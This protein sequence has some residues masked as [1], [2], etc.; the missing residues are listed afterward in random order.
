MRE[1]LGPTISL[2]LILTVVRPV[3]SFAESDG[4]RVEFESGSRRFK[5]KDYQGALA[6]FEKA[7][8]LSNHRPSVIRGLAQTERALE[9]YDRAI[10]HFKEYLES[11]PAEA[12]SIR[13]TIK[14]LELEK[15][16]AEASQKPSVTP[17]PPPLPAPE[18]SSIVAQAPPPAEPEEPSIF[19]SP[20]FWGVAGAVV[21]AGG[22]VAAAVLLSRTPDPSGGSTGVLLKPLEGPR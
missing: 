22:A 20:I 19:S 9:L 18:P 6:D 10:G 11:N 21:I 15:E 16:K 4:G 1:R 2:C 5:A 8:Q 7:Y 14:L 17:T 12:P 3:A 13:E